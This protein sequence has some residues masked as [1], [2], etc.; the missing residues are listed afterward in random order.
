MKRFIV[1]IMALVF[2]LG[3]A[4][5]KKYLDLTP[6][7]AASD[8]LVWSKV[9]YADLAVNNFYHDINYFGNFNSGQSSAGLTEGFTD[10]LKYSA[11]TYNANMFIPNELAYGGSVL[12]AGYV[13]TYMG[14]WSTVYDKIRRVNEALSNLKKYGG[15]LP[16]QDITR[17]EGEL[18]FFRAFLYFDILKRYKE[19]I[20]YDED[21][22]KIVK[23]ASLSSESQG[24]DFVE[25][26]LRFAAEKLAVSNNAKGRLTSG[27]AYAFMSRAMLYAKRWSAAQAAAEEVLK[28][29]YKLATTYA[30]AFKDGNAEAILQY[31]FD[32]RVFTHNFDFY[33]APGGDK[34][35]SGA[36]AT[37]TQEMV[38]SYE[39]AGTGG[40]PD[41][42][43][44]HSTSG[45]T[46]TPPYAQLEPRFQA[47]VLYNGASWKGRTIEAFVGGKDGYATWKEDAVP[48]GRSVTGYFLR[49]LLDE[50]LDLNVDNS[51]QPWIALRL[52][53]VLLNYA[54]ASY[55]NDAPAL[56]NDAIRKIRTRVGLPYVDKSGEALMA[57]IRQERK[58]ELAYEGLY[59]WDMRRW[60]LANT[61][62]TGNRVHG[63]KIEK[64]GSG[65]FVYTYVDCDKQDRNF[66]EKMYRF[67][68][69][70]SEITNNV[71]IN[72]FPEWN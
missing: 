69:P 20:I 21:L 50:S 57:Q 70:T 27:A 51:I 2:L 8:K 1:N 30:D 15:S 23:N 41:W 4:S 52:G 29:N 44:W 56:A 45:T 55:R 24:W 64:N 28:M 66:P 17:L 25:S 37:P 31:S 6:T 59:Y 61:A 3:L 18:R 36:Y 19:V 32:R 46:Q 71:S 72:Q 35:G 54:E 68:L 9:E 40:F 33:Y 7:S 49:K 43:V 47:S 26:D 60:G 22:T 14:T 16:E 48:A 58:V 62:F 67:P 63:L 10:M 13:A 5:C 34:E 11:M 42:S 39:L 53:E 65:Q 12:T 38:E